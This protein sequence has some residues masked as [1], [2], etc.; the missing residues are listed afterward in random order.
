MFNDGLAVVCS[1]LIVFRVKQKMRVWG[2]W[3]KGGELFHLNTNRL[4]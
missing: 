2:F 3:A 4:S 1:F